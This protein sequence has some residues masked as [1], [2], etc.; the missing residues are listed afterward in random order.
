M[1]EKYLEEAEARVLNLD[2]QSYYKIKWTHPFIW[3]VL[4][5]NKLDQLKKLSKAQQP[6]CSALC[7]RLQIETKQQST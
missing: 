4:K 7:V 5:E 2:N 3:H 1:E 6:G